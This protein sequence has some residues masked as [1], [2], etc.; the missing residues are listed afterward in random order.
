MRARLSAIAVT[1]VMA[2]GLLTACGDSTDDKKTVTL[3]THSSFN[4][5]KDVIKEF[6]NESG[7]RL[8]V[9]RDGDAGEAINKAILTK[10]NPQGDVFFG[11]DNT[12]LS[13]ALDEKLFDK[14]EPKDL[15]TVPE[16]LRLDP[17]GTATPIDTGDVCV[18]Y[19]KES[20]TSTPPPATLEDLTKPEYRDK[21]VVENPATSSPGLAFLLATVGQYGP[22]GYQGYWQRLQANGVEIVDGWDQAYFERFSGPGSNGDKPLVVS[23]ASSPV[24]EVVNAD[25]QPETPP[26]GVATG[27]CFRQIEFAGILNGTDNKD[28]AKKLLDFMLSKSFQE[29][30]PLNMYVDPVRD[31]VDVPPVYQKHATVIEQPINVN[32]DQIRDNR[33]TWIKGFQTA[34]GL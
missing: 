20:F 27:T 21:L 9:L 19:D 16:A 26:T 22:D 12:F 29:D 18:N 2:V 31:D 30:I 32:P 15:N 6:E 8:K 7:Y 11:V 23:Y 4:I 28:G 5:S 34:V 10:K 24:V 3:V 33:E 1:A 25:P 13:R 17:S 14:Y